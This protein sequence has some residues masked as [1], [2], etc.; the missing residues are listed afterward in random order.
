LK[1]IWYDF[2]RPEECKYWN[3][4]SVD[5]LPTASVILV[6]YNEGWS[7]LVRTFH[8]VIN[9]SPK[10]LLKDII[11]VDDYSDEEHITVRLPEYIKKWNGLVKY[12]RTKQR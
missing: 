2:C 9:T 6:F 1:K 12:V 8:S 5:K 10:Q 11:L 7:T 4:P 3:Y